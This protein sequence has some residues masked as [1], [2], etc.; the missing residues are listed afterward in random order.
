MT[1]RYNMFNYFETYAGG[2]SGIT[3]E[4]TKGLAPVGEIKNVGTYSIEIEFDETI[5]EVEA[6][7]DKIFEFS[8]LPKE[9]DLAD[10][11]ITFSKTLNTTDPDLVKTL[12]VLVGLSSQEIVIEFT[13]ESGELVGEYDLFVESIS[14]EH[15]EN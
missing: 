13:R 1:K 11:S 6:G 15:P 4:I 2:T 10:Y 7:V 9:I 5:F 14:S 12:N 8:V 3:F